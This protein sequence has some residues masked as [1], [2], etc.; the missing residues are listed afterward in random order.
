[1]NSDQR[2]QYDPTPSTARNDLVS[3]TIAAVSLFALA[4]VIGVALAVVGKIDTWPEVRAVGMVA[5][6]LGYL[7]YGLLTALHLHSVGARHWLQWTRTSAEVKF[8]RESYGLL[9]T[10]DDGRVDDSE[11][12][13]YTTYIRHLYRGGDATAATAWQSFR[14]SGPTWQHYKELTIRLNLGTAVNRR[15]GEGFELHPSVKAMPYEKVES[16]IRKHFQQ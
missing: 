4:V 1:M 9:D 14:I 10:N 8:L 12:A 2:I 7:P 11:L 16:L 15:G 6:I 13:A 3:A 5:L